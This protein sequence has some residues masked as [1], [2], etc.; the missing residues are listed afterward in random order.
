MAKQLL[1]DLETTGI[2]F[3]IHAIHQISGIVLIDGE[4]KEEFDYRVAP[5]PTAVI[6]PEALKVSNVTEEQIKAYPANILVHKQLTGM[7]AKYVNKFDKLDKFQLLGYNN[8][9]FDGDFFRVFFN[10]CGDNYFGSWFWNGSSDVMV[11][12]ADYL[13]DERHLLPN[14][15]LRT[16]AAH[17]GIPVDTTKLHDARYDIYLTLEIYKIV[18]HKKPLV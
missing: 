8:V 5:H 6:D 17:L 7:F 12:A 16:V 1:Y 13:Q 3:K 18:S 4:V 15:Q 14:F 10:H 9:K 11:L 2:D